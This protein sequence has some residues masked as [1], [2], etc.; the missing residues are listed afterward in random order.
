M[1]LIYC[2]RKGQALCVTQ[3]QFLDWFTDNFSA[4]LITKEK[5]LELKQRQANL[6]KYKTLEYEFMERFAIEIH[7]NNEIQYIDACWQFTQLTENDNKMVDLN[8]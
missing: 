7:I 8:N 4:E 5:Y 3:D 2:I 6:P 1:K